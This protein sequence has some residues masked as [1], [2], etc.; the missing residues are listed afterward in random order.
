MKEL[1]RKKKKKSKFK[2][3]VYLV[4]L[5]SIL[6][7][8]KSQPDDLE[9]LKTLHKR[10]V[11]YVNDLFYVI[12]QALWYENLPEQRLHLLYNHALHRL[13]LVPLQAVLNNV[14]CFD[15]AKYNAVSLSA[16]PTHK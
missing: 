8:S 15:N 16:N 14:F 7:P 5:E 2:L 13:G 10:G 3:S 6:S 1:N 11:F 12:L 4:R 9:Y